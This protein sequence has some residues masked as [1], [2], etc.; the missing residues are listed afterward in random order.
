M[1]ARII[2]SSPAKVRNDAIKN[3]FIPDSMT[4]LV[5]KV[6]NFK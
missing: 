4:V 5:V 6:N 2:A 1:T 3:I